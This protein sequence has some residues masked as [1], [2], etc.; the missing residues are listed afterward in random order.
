MS[1]TPSQIYALAEQIARE[2]GY[3]IPYL[4]GWTGWGERQPWGAAT[5][6]AM[7]VA[8]SHHLI[9]GESDATPTLLGRA[10]ASYLAS[11][12]R[13]PKGQDPQGLDAKHESAAAKPDAQPPSGTPS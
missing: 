13:S 11:A 12:D 5:S 2:D 7:E 4:L 6:F 1:R 8:A 10:V 9:E 3:L